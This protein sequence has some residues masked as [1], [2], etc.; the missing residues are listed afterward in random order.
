MIPLPE[1]IR[2]TRLDEVVGQDHL[3]GPAGLLT[4]FL[5]VGQLPSLLLWGPPG[6]GKTTIARLLA[7]AA[8]LRFAPFS[9]VLSGLPDLRAAL[10]EA[11]ANRTFGEGTLLFIDELHRFNK[12]QQDALLPHVE[13]GTIVLVGV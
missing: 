2:P 10:E 9:A 4:R 8:T 5:A 6:C 3:V 11:K 1:R 12:S 7:Q 13:A